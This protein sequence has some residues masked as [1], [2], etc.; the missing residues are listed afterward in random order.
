MDIK[1]FYPS[2]YPNRA[3]EISRLM[4]EKSDVKI[5]NV[6]FDILAKYLGKFLTNEKIDREDIRELVYTKKPKEKKKIAKKISKKANR[7]KSF[8]LRNIEK[9]KKSKVEIEEENWLKPKKLPN[10]A[11]AKRMLGIALELLIVTC[12]SNHM[13]KFN[14]ERRLQDGEG[15]TGLDLTGLVADIF[16]LWWDDQ[17]QEKLTASLHPL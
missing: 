13:Y 7:S 2:I 8:E 6:N 16:M 3:A 5:E 11:E 14:G 12:M 9:K 17:Y 1:S 4:F 10:S 15:P